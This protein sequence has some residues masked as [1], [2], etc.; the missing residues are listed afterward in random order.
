MTTIQYEHVA[1]QG[2]LSRDPNLK[3][4]M[5]WCSFRRKL[6]ITGY[7]KVQEPSKSGNSKIYQSVTELDTDSEIPVEEVKAEVK[8]K[9]QPTTVQQIQDERAENK[10]YE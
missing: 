2:P 3:K 7:E 5:M 6:T 1:N 10:K 8:K 9:G 4:L